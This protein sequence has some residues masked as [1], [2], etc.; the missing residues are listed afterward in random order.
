M[1]QTSYLLAGVSNEACFGH[2][3]RTLSLFPFMDILPDPGNSLA[4]EDVVTEEVA[5]SFSPASV[6]GNSF[7]FSKEAYWVRFSLEMEQ[8]LNST[9]LLQL[10]SPLTDRVELYIPDKQGGYTKKITGE[11]LPFT[12]REID[13]RTFLFNLPLYKGEVQTYYMRLQ[14]EGSLQ[15]PLSLWSQDAFIEH[16][17]TNN[18]ILGVYFGIMLLLVLVALTS[19]QKMRDKLF[20]AYAL[21]LCS[22]LLLQLSLNGFGFQYLWPNLPEWSNRVTAA[23][24]GLAVLFGLLFSGMFLQVLGKKHPRVKPFFTT[25][26]VLSATSVGMSLYGDFA[27]AAKYAT[28][29]GMLLPPIVLFGAISALKAGY[30]PARYFLLAW[31]IFLCGVFV[32]GLLFLG[33]VPHTFATFYAMQI[34][35]T[36]EVL[37]L[38]YALMDRIELLRIEKSRANLLASQCMLQL[39]TELESLVKIRTQELEKINVEL[40]EMATHDCMTGLLTHSASL[41]FLKLMQTSALRYGGGLAVLMVDIDHFKLINDKYG[42]PAGDQVIKSIADVLKASIRVS[43]ACGRYGG[44]EFILI[45][46]RSDHSSA[47]QLAERVRTKIQQLKISEINHSPVTA[48][49]GIAILDPSEP[50]ENLVARAD[51]ALYE[52]KNAGRNRVMLSES[53]STI[54]EVER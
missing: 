13:Y 25:G 18:M 41:D 34:G 23:S 9:I 49:L 16:V 46:A 5:G 15:I 37:L 3:T 45:L 40:R 31:C 30:K 29:L 44:E 52:A 53:T 39:N 28:I 50:N 26:M 1:S 12:Q 27:L 22:Y 4:I 48:S 10:D 33:F 42:H 8:S 17:D 51:K 43:D 21:Y 6:M 54:T 14:T 35:S 2:D 7:G 32:A 19:F 11:T 47:V 20:L 36:F 38:G 24:V